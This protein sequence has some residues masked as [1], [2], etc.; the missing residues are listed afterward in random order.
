MTS[1]RAELSS[2]IASKYAPGLSLALGSRTGS[3]TVESYS[4]TYGGVIQI[5]GCRFPV[6]QPFSF[7]NVINSPSFAF[8]FPVMCPFYHVIILYIV[9]PGRSLR[10]FADHAEG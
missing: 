4:L 6:L 7:S 5:S 9:L 8:H 10:L 1:K 3:G 2:H